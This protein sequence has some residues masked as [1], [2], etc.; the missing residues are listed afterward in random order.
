MSL[1][2][3]AQ[4]SQQS[5]TAVRQGNHI[6][7]LTLITITYAKGIPETLLR[8][9]GYANT[10]GKQLQIS[11]TLTLHGM[12]LSSP[13]TVPYLCVPLVCL[14]DGYHAFL[15]QLRYLWVGSFA[16]SSINCPWCLQCGKNDRWGPGLRGMHSEVCREY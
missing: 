3:A 14:W 15:R 1:E 11:T 6:R 16:F 5:A 13:I 10:L 7:I 2:V 12:Y 4:A 8:Q 9:F